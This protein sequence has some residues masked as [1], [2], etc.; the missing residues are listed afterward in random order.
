MLKSEG[1]PMYFMRC[2][3]TMTFKRANQRGRFA[4]TLVEVVISILVIALM[5]VGLIYGYVQSNRFAEWSSY[6]LAAQS[7]ASQGVER[8]KAAQWGSS[9]TGT[10]LDQLG[11]GTTNE[12]GVILVPGTGQ[13]LTV[14]DTVTTTTY[15][16]NP[17]VRQIV[18]QCVWQFPSTGQKYTNTVITLRSSN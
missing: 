17:P 13:S 15:L 14:T 8:V 9:I 18:S 6:S 2:Q 1:R 10:Y 12:T 16:S 3:L 7:L 4:F 5:A 11:T